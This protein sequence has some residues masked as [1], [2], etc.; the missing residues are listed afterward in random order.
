VVGS[1][2]VL[3]EFVPMTRAAVH[4]IVGAGI[5]VAATFPLAALTALLF[6]FPIPFGG[7]ANGVDAVVPALLA[8]AFYGILGGFIVQAILGGLAGLLAARS[9][10]GRTSFVFATAAA[11]PGVLLLS[12]LDWIIGPW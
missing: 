3:A 9:T 10:A 1:V 12:I 8:V 6:R 7:Y 11:L 5:A 2:A 4:I